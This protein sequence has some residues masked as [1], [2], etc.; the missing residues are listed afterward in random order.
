MFCKTTMLL[1]KTLDIKL[2][3]KLDQTRSRQTNDKTFSQS[4]RTIMACVRK[5]SEISKICIHT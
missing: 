1:N 3:L 5:C 2:K 4:V